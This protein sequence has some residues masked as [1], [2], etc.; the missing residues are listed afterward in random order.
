MHTEKT[1]D[2]AVADIDQVSPWYP[3]ILSQNHAATYF[4]CSGWRFESEE[5]AQ[6]GLPVDFCQS[7]FCVVPRTQARA[8]E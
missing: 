7:L 6:P 4:A 1:R 5:T 8:S 2:V 3:I